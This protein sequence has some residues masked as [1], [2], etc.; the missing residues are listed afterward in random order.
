M[1]IQSHPIVGAQPVAA[2]VDSPARQ[3]AE[4]AA[5]IS[6]DVSA[7][8]VGGL[9]KNVVPANTVQAEQV[10]TTQEDVDQAV[11][12]INDAVRTFSQKLEF[13]VDKETETFVVKVVDKETKEVI[14]QI[15]SEEFLQIAKA[16]DKLQ[17]L[18]IKD[19]A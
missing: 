3:S 9:Q 16:M 5:S 12:K 17:G 10:A 1:Q 8:S 18:L 19:K 14:R 13:S 2:L 15:P 7:A 11:E 4:S 6:S